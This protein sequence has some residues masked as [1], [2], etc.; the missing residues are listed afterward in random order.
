MQYMRGR[1]SLLGLGFALFML[2]GSVGCAGTHS[3]THSPE[4]VHHGL[5]VVGS[6][7]ASGAPDVARVNL[8]V[9]VRADTVDDATRQ[10]NTRMKAVLDA[11]TKAGVEPRD[12]RTQ[13][14]SVHEEREWN[15]QP[16]P[17]PRPLP[18]GGAAS[19]EGSAGPDQAE[20]ASQAFYV[21]ENMLELTV[22]DLDRLGEILGLALS[23]GGNQLHG[24][25]LELDDPGPLTRLAQ[26]R[27]LQDAQSQAKEL[28]RLAGRRLGRILSIRVVG[29]SGGP[30]PLPMGFAERMD[31]KAANTVP[32][33]AGELTVHEQVEIH[34]EL[35]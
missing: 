35:D 3:S 15:P 32:V 12:L 11:L 31:A 25:N 29:G 4:G 24:I 20:A 21:A 14:L 22:R 28:A 18:E 8:G 7:K 13:N 19:A 17:P 26:E 30:G 27:A 34:F 2:V 5:W 10:A 23:A 33:Q 16:P 1:T 9:R 6:G